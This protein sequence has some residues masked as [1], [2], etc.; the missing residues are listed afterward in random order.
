MGDLLLGQEMN[1]MKERA[2]VDTNIFVYSYT[3]YD[4]NKQVLAESLL[5][6]IDKKT[7]LFISIQVIKEFCA[8]MKKHNTETALLKNYVEEIINSFVVLSTR[9]KTIFKSIENLNKYNL[10]WYDTILITTAINNDCKIFY[11]EDLKNG[12]IIEN[13]MT[14][15]NPF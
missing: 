11:S 8:T 10:S 15:I 2:F 14:V 9:I 12:L 4:T 3:N 7:D 13:K 5:Q 6:N 1:Y